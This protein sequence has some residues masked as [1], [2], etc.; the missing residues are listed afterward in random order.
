MLIPRFSA[1][2]DIMNGRRTRTGF[3]RHG[4]I[5]FAL[6]LSILGTATAAQDIPAVDWSGAYGGLTLG[7]AA[8]DGEARRGDY[9]GPLLSLD[10]QNGLFPAAIDGSDAK[11]FVGL[12]LGFSVQRGAFVGGIE[13]DL[14]FLDQSLRLDFSRVDP[15]PNPIFNGIDTN[16]RYVTEFGTLLTLRLRGGYAQGRNLFYATAGLA[17]AEVR[18]DFALDLPD[19]GYASPDWSEQ[20]TLHGYAVGLGVERRVTDRVSLKAEIVHFD[21][22]NVTIEGRDPAVFP[23]ESLDYEF[24]NSGTLARLGVNFA[25]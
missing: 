20:S 6:A 18:N 3:E 8:S 11:G 7:F 22:E 17:A 14:A 9:A 13:A 24:Q 10:V 16:T 23:G 2:G 12:G 19:L 4:V 21:L 15:N 25:F 1:K 5:P